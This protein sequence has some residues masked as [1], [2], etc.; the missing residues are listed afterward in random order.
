M[1]IVVGFRGAKFHCSAILKTEIIWELQPPYYDNKS[2]VR[3]A[4]LELETHNV[5][6][7]RLEMTDINIPDILQ[8]WGKVSEHIYWIIYFH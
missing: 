7:V 3:S 8:R 2:D 4:V 5:T 6:E 1:S